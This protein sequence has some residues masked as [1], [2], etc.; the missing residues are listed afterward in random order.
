MKLATKRVLT[1]EAAKHI[2]RAAQAEAARI[3]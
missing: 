3:P 2:A 1:L